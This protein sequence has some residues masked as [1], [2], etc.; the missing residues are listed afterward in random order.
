M[1]KVKQYWRTTDKM[2][3]AICASLSVISVVTLCSVAQYGGL[4][5]T[6]AFGNWRP[7]ITQALASA[8]GL[9]GAV[10]L[11]LVDYRKLARMWP[12][13]MAVC[14][15]LVLLTFIPGVGYEPAGTGSQSWIAMPF[16][17]SIQ[18]T[19]LAKISFYLSFAWHL[20]TVH[21]TLS[22]PKT[23]V[24]VLLHLA[25]PVLVVHLQGDDGTA[26]VFLAIGV[27]ML[28][29]AGL[30]RWV[31]ISCV[32]AVAAAVPLVWRYVMSGYQKERILG[33]FYPEQYVDT[34]M[35]QQLR[36]RQAIGAGQLLGRGLFQ[37]GHVYVPRSENDFIFSYIAECCG[38]VGCL[39]V[40]GLLF[41]LMLKILKAAYTAGDRVG[42]YMCVGV[43]ATLLFQTVVNVGMNL[44][45][46]PVMGVT[47]PFLSAGGTS[48]LML[49]LSMGLVLSVKRN[50]TGAL[51]V[52]TDKATL[53][54]ESEGKPIPV[55][56]NNSQQ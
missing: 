54:V 13:H 37:P 31:V 39:V 32:T 53:A 1:E 25:V 46:L 18:P 36:G 41:G 12:L 42:A 15:G 29:T 43:F 4:T 38:F 51:Q 33:L 52:A 47:L 50:R 11:S 48:V 20:S 24:W 56:H 26:L 35:Y 34:I 55:T 10:L 23:L 45:L 8:L 28:F 3:L 7:A 2:Y 21:D 5:Y 49:Y 22:K 17:M 19:E 9:V 44:M 16:G 30:N 40:L 14:W 6:G 27:V